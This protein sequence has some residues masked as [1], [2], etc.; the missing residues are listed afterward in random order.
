M[1]K[2]LLLNVQNPSDFECQCLNRDIWSDETVKEIIKANFVFSQ[3]YFDSPEGKKLIH[4]YNIDSYPFL[5]II[6]PRT[7]EKM[8]Q[9]NCLK[10]DAWMFCEKTTNFLSDH[11]APMSVE[12]H[13]ATLRTSS[14]E[15]EEKKAEEVIDLN[16]KQEHE[17]RRA[18]RN[19]AFNYSES[20]LYPS[21]EL[22]PKK[23]SQKAKRAA[24]IIQNICTN[25]VHK[26]QEEEEEEEDI[27]PKPILNGHHK[28]TNGQSLNQRKE[29][30]K[31][32]KKEVK[33]D[34]EEEEEVSI[35]EEPSE[36]VKET[37]QN[38]FE[39]QDVTIKDCFIR[40]L[41]PDGQRLD[42]NINGD[43]TI[44]ALVD[45]LAKKGYRRRTHSLVERMMMPGV[46]YS[47]IQSRNLLKENRSK[48]FKEL[49]LFPRVFLMVQEL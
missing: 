35:I 6:D 48:T 16:D 29:E 12:E 7:G 36:V 3:V 44:N 33:K 17:T 1:N 31:E 43:A 8:T 25:G 24:D 2:W 34:V 9:M 39:Q 28:L 38:Y 41:L 47:E 37:R 26:D 14:N 32:V 22:T 23:S 18:T 20:K 21:N 45:I 15:G 5:A 13:E 30:N 40:V 42:L 46:S 27:K 4:Y 11:E 10:L 49:N 19:G